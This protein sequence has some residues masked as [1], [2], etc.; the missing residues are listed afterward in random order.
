MFLCD[1]VPYILTLLPYVTFSYISTPGH[2]STPGT[3]QST[4]PSL[5]IH[6]SP[7]GGD[8]ALR[9]GRLSPS[10]L[11]PIR[12]GPLL[13]LRVEQP[14]PVPGRVTHRGEPVL[15]VQ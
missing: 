4:Y 12:D 3:D 11:Y 6:E 8:L 13:P 15:R 1:C 10:Q 14:P 7:G 9:S 2:V 5:L